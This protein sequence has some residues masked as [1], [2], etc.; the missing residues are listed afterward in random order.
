MEE[1]GKYSTLTKYL[2]GKYWELKKK[3]RARIDGNEL[4]NLKYVM[5]NYVP[6]TF[7]LRGWNGQLT[8]LFYEQLLTH[9]E[10]LTRQTVI[11]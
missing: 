2:E 3:F 10:L 4:F 6:V 8:D 1:D 11:A 9:M 7:L 5:R